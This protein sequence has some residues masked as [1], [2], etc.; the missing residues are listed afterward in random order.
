MSQAIG[1]RK[2]ATPTVRIARPLPASARTLLQIIA[3]VR[4]GRIEQLQICNGEA[5]LF[6]FPTVVRT[7]KFV[8]SDARAPYTSPE[9]ML[10]K[11][12]V[13]AWLEELAAVTNGC[14]LRLEVRDG[15]PA[16]MEVEVDA[17][18]EVAHG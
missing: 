7:V 4:F 16:F 10:A 18:Q 2:T 14:I 13:A 11:P 17:G 5:A 1:Q 8:A 6:P 15:L 12:Q 3:D 9:E